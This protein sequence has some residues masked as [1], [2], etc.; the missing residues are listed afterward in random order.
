MEQRA[1]T[2]LRARSSPEGAGS[3]RVSSSTLS[4]RPSARRAPSAS[5]GTQEAATAY[6]PP[7]RPASGRPRRSSQP[8]SQPTP[9]RRAEGRAALSPS[10][11]SFATGTAS[12]AASRYRGQAVVRGVWCALSGCWQC[13]PRQDL[14]PDCRY[15]RPQPCPRDEHA[16]EPVRRARCVGGAWAGLIR[17]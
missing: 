10:A 12:S 14:L 17:V 6:P 8:A 16:G 11:R 4:A 13:W 7:A 1:A 3:Q 9:P 5:K 2:T 15:P